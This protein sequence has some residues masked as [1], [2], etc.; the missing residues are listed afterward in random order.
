MTQ[1]SGRSP[2]FY[3]GCGCLFMI[4]VGVAGS[5]LL[6]LWARNLQ[7]DMKSA[8]RRAEKAEELLGLDQLPEGYQVGVAMGIPMV[9]DT[10]ILTDG[11][12]APDGDVRRP[13]FRGEHGF[14]Y[15]RTLKIGGEDRLLD[16]FEGR[17]EDD[18]ALEQAG[19][20]L[21][22]DER[23]GRGEVDIAGGK[24]LWVTHRGEVDV[25]QD[26]RDGLNTVVM[27]RCAEK[28][29]RRTAIWWGPDPQ[30]EAS[31]DAIDLSGSVGDAAR[32]AEFL[33]PMRLCT[34]N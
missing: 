20:N 2:W 18:K 11:E 7:E 31:A 4:A 24:A 27:F 8:D 32:I 10:V 12:A 19:I 9:L 22:L 29:G 1:E 3:V 26:S 14:L 21:R 33:A 34:A 25:L 13:Q 23:V 15:T 28:G 17:T 6:A 5:I 16:F 30:P